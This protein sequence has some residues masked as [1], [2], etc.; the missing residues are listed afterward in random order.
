MSTK[1][2][3]RDQ[4]MVGKLMVIFSWWKIPIPAPAGIDR[5][6]SLRRYEDALDELICAWVGSTP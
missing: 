6:G 3:G 2:L 5:L 1:D 4:L